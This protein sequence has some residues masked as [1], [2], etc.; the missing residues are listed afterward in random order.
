MATVYE[1][2]VK[3][4]IHC[5]ITCAGSLSL[6]FVE[7]SNAKHQHRQHHQCPH[8]RRN[9]LRWRSQRRQ[10]PTYIIS[11]VL[12][13]AFCFACIAQDTGCKH[14]YIYEMLTSAEAN[15]LTISASVYSCVTPHDLCRI[16]NAKIGYERNGLAKVSLRRFKTNEKCWLLWPVH[17]GSDANGLNKTW[18]SAINYSTK[19]EFKVDNEFWHSRESLASLQNNYFVI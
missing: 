17:A 10:L 6:Q 3:W 9:I 14:L 2:W 13:I 18:A 1:I 4:K 16:V 11:S 7:F 15:G 5:T 8:K 19:I 12:P